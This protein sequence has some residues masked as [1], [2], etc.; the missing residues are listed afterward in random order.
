MLILFDDVWCLACLKHLEANTQSPLGTVFFVLLV[1]THS[2]RLVC[3][4]VVNRKSTFGYTLDVRDVHG[5]FGWRRPDLCGAVSQS[6]SETQSV[7]VFIIGFYIFGHQIDLDLVKT[8]L[9][10]VE[11]A[12][13]DHPDSQGQFF[14]GVVEARRSEAPS[15]HSECSLVKRIIWVLGPQCW[16]EDGRKW[17]SYEE[18]WTANRKEI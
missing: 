2:H 3:I 18:N 14:I 13:M 17:T 7:I 8:W 16:H 10:V 5:H 1:E 6:G 11:L 4:Q 12:V 15:K 9:S